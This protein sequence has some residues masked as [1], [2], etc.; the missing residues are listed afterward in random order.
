MIAANIPLETSCISAQV[1][2]KGLAEHEKHRLVEPFLETIRGI[3]ARD[4]L[5]QRFETREHIPGFDFILKRPNKD[6]NIVDYLIVDGTR[7]LPERGLYRGTYLIR[8]PTTTINRSLSAQGFEHLLQQ[9][10]SDG[11]LPG[12]ALGAMLGIAAGFVATHPEYLGLGAIPGSLWGLLEGGILDLAVCYNSF[13]KYF[14]KGEHLI[15]TSRKP[16][17]TNVINKALPVSLS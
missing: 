7:Q 6:G 10:L 3:E 9:E 11:S 17:D 15:A 14:R 1:L 4:P 12:A 8:L 16:Y 2:A 5:Y 13:D